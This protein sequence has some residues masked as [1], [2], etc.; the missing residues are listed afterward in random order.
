MGSLVDIIRIPVMSID[1]LGAGFL[2][3]FRN[4]IDFGS[5]AL[6]GSAE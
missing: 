6:F 5:A 3:S 4:L 2:N 1:A